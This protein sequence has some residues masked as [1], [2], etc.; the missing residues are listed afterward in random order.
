MRDSVRLFLRSL[1]NHARGWLW[2]YRAQ[3]CYRRRAKARS[4]AA[5]A[6]AM[7]AREAVLDRLQ[8]Q[9]AELLANLERAAVAHAAMGAELA[10]VEWKPGR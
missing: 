6:Q 8:W 9:I 5:L 7:A 3:P 10:L 4:Q 1:L 2:A